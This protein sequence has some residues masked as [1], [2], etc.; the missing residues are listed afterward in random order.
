MTCYCPQA[1]TNDKPSNL[2]HMM[3]Q[4]DT[5]TEMQLMDN[6]IRADG[7]HSIHLKSPA[8]LNLFLHI[9]GQRADGYH[10]LQTIFQLIDAADEMTFAINQPDGRAYSD[11]QLVVSSETPVTHDVEDNLVYKAA[12]L[13]QF[14]TKTTQ[15]CHITLEK[16]LPAGGGIGGGSSNAATTL[17]AL[18]T[19]WNTQ[20][21]LNTLAE[22]GSQL[23]ADVPVFIHGH[24]AWA[25]GIGEQ[26]S[27]CDTAALIPE[28]SYIVVLT[29]AVHASTA[30]L[31]SHPA[32]VRDMPKTSAVEVMAQPSQVS[33]VF[34][35]VVTDIF[36]EIASALDYLKAYVSR[37][38]ILQSGSVTP[39][40]T[41]TGASVFAVF[42]SQQHAQDC[43][44][45]APCSGILCRPIA[46]S[47]VHTTLNDMPNH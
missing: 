18:N 43:L 1:Y 37:P 26:L 12:A 21:S 17:L 27:L 40:L 13:L 10:E 34:E 20:L 38:D 39:R 42:A 30:S 5:Q 8:K 2:P 9:T 7:S 33:N 31:F 11:I 35:P 36:A 6:A 4:I 47:M 46:M 32:L 23:G 28:G 41:G 44:T 3:K 14:V 19:L 24:T 45:Q 16:K 25:E 29:P 15:G 22:L